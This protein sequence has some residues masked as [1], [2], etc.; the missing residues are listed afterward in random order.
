MTLPNSPLAPMLISPIIPAPHMFASCSPHVRLIHIL[1]YTC[2]TS[3]PLILMYAA[4]QCPTLRV[5]NHP[6]MYP[7]TPYVVTKYHLALSSSCPTRKF[8][9]TLRQARPKAHT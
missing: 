5:Y 7:C 1:M 6:R 8:H 9:T 3:P 2:L 4:R